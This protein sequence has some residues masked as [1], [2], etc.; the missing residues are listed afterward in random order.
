MVVYILL[1]NDHYSSGRIANQCF[2]LLSVYH[3]YVYHRCSRFD[4]CSKSFP[5]VPCSTPTEAHS[6]AARGATEVALP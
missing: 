6:T 2:K 4:M 5:A 1:V 3:M